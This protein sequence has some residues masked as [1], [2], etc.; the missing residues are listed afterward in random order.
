V[1]DSIFSAYRIISPSANSEILDSSGQIKDA[2]YIRNWLLTTGTPD[3]KPIPI[4]GLSLDSEIITTCQTGN[5]ASLLLIGLKHAGFRNVKMYEG[6][7]SEWNGSSV[8]H[9]I[10]KRGHYNSST[11]VFDN[12]Y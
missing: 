12:L 5:Q 11:G 6:S 9:T 10:Y 4:P 7:W 3:S 8:D 1:N 2:Q